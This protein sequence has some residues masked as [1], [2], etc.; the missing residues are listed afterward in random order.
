[1]GRFLP[2]PASSGS[3][4]IATRNSDARN[5]TTPNATAARGFCA[6]RS[7]ARRGIGGDCIPPTIVRIEQ[8]W[9]AAAAGSVNARHAASAD[10]PSALSAACANRMSPHRRRLNHR[11]RRRNCPSTV[12]EPRSGGI[13]PCSAARCARRSVWLRV[14][15][16]GSWVTPWMCSRCSTSPV[17]CL[18]RSSAPLVLTNRWNS[19]SLSNAARTTFHRSRRS[20]SYLWCRAMKRLMLSSSGSTIGT[21]S[22]VGLRQG[23]QSAW[24][25]TCMDGLGRGMSG[26]P[27]RTLF[28]ATD[29]RSARYLRQ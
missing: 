18:A 5:P 7:R 17:S 9:A 10:G 26:W 3:A 12:A 11:E 27:Q 23:E 6:H 24:L 13:T 21:K 29:G 4:F 19:R 1:M 14:R 28:A 2:L 22:R 25:G 16:P 8:R 15:C 20:G